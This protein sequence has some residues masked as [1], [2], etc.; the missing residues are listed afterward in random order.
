MGIRVPPGIGERFADSEWDLETIVN[1]DNPLLRSDIVAVQILCM[2][3]VQSSANDNRMCPS[4][5][6]GFVWQFKSAYFD[7]LLWD[8]F[9][10]EHRRS[11]L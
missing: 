1:I 11:V 3:Q 8:R 6:L 9:P 5:A 4:P 2:T 7:E 10:K